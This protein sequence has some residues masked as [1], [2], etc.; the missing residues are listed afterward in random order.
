MSIENELKKDG[1]TS[2]QPLDT[3]SITLIA[4]FVA[5]KYISYF[6]FSHMRY[7]DLYSRVSRIKMYTANIPDGM[8]EAGYLYKNDSIYF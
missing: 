7:N 1:I 8:A 6:P 4:K 3:L 5:E 2:I